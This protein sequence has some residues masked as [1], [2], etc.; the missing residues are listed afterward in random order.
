M[1]SSN[2]IENLPDLAAEAPV[3]LAAA[4]A[5]SAVAPPVRLDGLLTAWETERRRIQGSA[6]DFNLP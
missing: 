3:A 4:V 6:I 5:D 1:T 2:P